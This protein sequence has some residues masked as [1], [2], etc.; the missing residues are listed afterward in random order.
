M[1]K[2]FENY[3]YQQ[4]AHHHRQR[5]RD[6]HVAHVGSVYAHAHIYAVIYGLLTVKI[7]SSVI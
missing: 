3:F 5:S 6:Y 2:L 7:S 1:L 4:H